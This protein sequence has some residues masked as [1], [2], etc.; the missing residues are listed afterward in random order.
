[1]LQNFKASGNGAGRAALAFAVLLLFA[2]FAWA[3][4]AG[5]LV[6][7]RC[8][9]CHG[10]DK[11]CAVTVDDAEWWKETVSRM[12]EYKSDLLSAGEVAEVGRYLADGKQRAALCSSN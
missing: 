8:Q 11:T 1:M 9:G 4:D 7:L 2:S 5:E 12:V 10:M 3:G 6:T